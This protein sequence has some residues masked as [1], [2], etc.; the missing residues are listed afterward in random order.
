MTVTFKVFFAFMYGLVRQYI[1]I[2]IY[3]I[4]GYEMSSLKTGCRNIQEIQRKLYVL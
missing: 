1:K 4:I 2:L 3:V